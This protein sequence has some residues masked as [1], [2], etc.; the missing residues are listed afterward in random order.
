MHAARMKNIHTARWELGNITRE[1]GSSYIYT[2]V[3]RTALGK[4][5]GKENNRKQKWRLGGGFGSYVG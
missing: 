5:P 2:T 1:I 4:P 3:L